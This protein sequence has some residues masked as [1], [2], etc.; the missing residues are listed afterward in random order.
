VARRLFTLTS[1]LSLLL[2]LAVCVLWARSYQLMDEVTWRHIGGVR[3]ARTS[4]AHL[5]VGA[6]VTNSAPSQPGDSF[7]FKYR[8][9]RANLPMNPFLYLGPDVGDMNFSWERGD[10][11]W[12]S[13]SNAVTGYLDAELIV[14]FW[15]IAAVMAVTPLG[16][17]TLWWRSRVRN[18]RY[19]SLGLCPFCGYDLRATPSRCPECGKPVISSGA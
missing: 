19:K 2:C 4:K 7:G 5:E 12:Y 18:R 8:R 15:G 9:E 16:W 1:A 11:A 14:P 13:K 6:Y 3:W 17:T 10:F